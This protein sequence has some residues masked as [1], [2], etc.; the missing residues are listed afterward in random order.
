MTLPN[1]WFDLPYKRPTLL[2]V[3]D[4]QSIIHLI[5]AF[6]GPQYT[7]HIATNG[8]EALELAKLHKPDLILLD[9]VMPQMDGYEVC[10][11]LKAD[12]ALQ[13]IPIIF[14]T[15]R[16]NE[17]DEVK[18]LELGAVDFIRKPL[19]PVITRARIKAQVQLKFQ[20]DL[21]R[22]I[23]LIDGLTG[24]ANRHRLED[25]LHTQWRQCARDQEPLSIVICDLDYFKQF[26]DTYGHLEGDGCLRT[27]AQTLKSIILRPSD[28]AARYGGE[29][30]MLLLPRTDLQGAQYVV[31]ELFRQIELQAIEHKDSPFGV[32]TISAGIATGYPKP[33]SRYDSIM[34][35]ADKQLY[36][37]KK[38]GRNQFFSHLMPDSDPPC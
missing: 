22:S 11:R 33:A 21:L 10:R 24:I 37:A 35:A 20:S 32:V 23:A 27:I 9:V 34:Q 15:G 5:H 29:E 25:E 30:F 19:N 7:V 6:L 1:H 13:I 36:K 38:Q 4:Q 3:D 18:G 17:E 14:I 26:N 16:D 31:Q 12:P 8:A 2:I 28:M